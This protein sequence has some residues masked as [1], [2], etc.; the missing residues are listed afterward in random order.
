MS[1]IEWMTND[2]ASTTGT[3]HRVQSCFR[4][5]EDNDV[6]GS[7]VEAGHRQ[8]VSFWIR[9]VPSDVILCDHQVKG[10]LHI[11]LSESLVN[12]PGIGRT[13]EPECYTYALAFSNEFDCSVGQNN[14][15]LYQTR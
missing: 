1:S 2:D 5:L 13:D 3:S 10:A 6:F 14:S 7:K 9:F 12:H 11:E 8:Q 15:R 4:V